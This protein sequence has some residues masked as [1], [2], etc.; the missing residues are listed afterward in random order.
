MLP[1]MLVAH[2]NDVCNGQIHETECNIL[3]EFAHFIE[4]S[5]IGTIIHYGFPIIQSV[6]GMEYHVTLLHGFH[7]IALTITFHGTHTT[8]HWLKFHW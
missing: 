6:I 3:V 5:K 7:F 1:M 2:G 8:I 4:L